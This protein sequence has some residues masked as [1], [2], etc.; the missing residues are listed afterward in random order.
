MIC[1]GKGKMKHISWDFRGCCTSKVGHQECQQTCNVPKWMISFRWLLLA[2]WLH[3]G[4]RRRRDPDSWWMKAWVLSDGFKN[5]EKLRTIWGEE[6]SNPHRNS[7]DG[8]NESISRV[9]LREIV[10]III[11]LSEWEPILPN[12][13]NFWMT[14][15][16]FSSQVYRGMDMYH[17]RWCRFWAVK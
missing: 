5:L 8:Y 10:V 6:F 15:S 7:Q 4:L 11:R 17:L 14:N 9:F 3:L 13:E 2:T 12:T 1:R 16:V